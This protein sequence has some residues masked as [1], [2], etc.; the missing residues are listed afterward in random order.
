[1]KSGM[2]SRQDLA[3][4]PEAD[5]QRRWLLTALALAGCGPCWADARS[6]QAGHRP[7][8]YERAALPVRRPTQAVLLAVARAGDRL[9]AVGERGLIILSD[10]G[11]RAWTQVPVPV[12]VTLTSVSFSNPK[13]GWATG[14]MGIVLR[15]RDGGQTWARVLDGV[16]AATLALQAAQALQR[17]APGSGADQ[18]AERSLD[19]AQRLVAEGADKPFLDIQV[20][21]GAGPLVAVGAYG[22]AFTSD[23][24]GISWAPLMLR[25]PNAEGLTLYGAV[26]RGRE[27]W[28]YGEQG[29]LLCADARSERY[30]LQPAVTSGSLFAAV[31]L[32][33]G[34]LLLMGLRG[35]VARSAEPGAGWTTVQ[36]PVDAS[37]FKG[38]QLDDG[39]VALVGA[40]GQLLISPD[41]GQQFRPV[42]L[43]HRFPFSGLAAAPDGALIVVGRR[44]VIRV[45]A[46]SVQGTRGAPSSDARAPA[47]NALASSDRSGKVRAP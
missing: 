21:T 33:E 26:D 27:R 39:S 16:A 15:T 7:A 31:V 30:V 22:L 8:A 19:D 41:L 42:A 4:V 36:T 17:S 18:E 25:L 28:L 44:G 3:T 5:V 29:F 45:P 20:P 1:M 12:S 14:S 2:V 40:A 43:E 24:E 10:D 34:P 23:D 37:L 35:R 11:G 6:A 47:S 46:V 9:V 38:I 32:R 13:L